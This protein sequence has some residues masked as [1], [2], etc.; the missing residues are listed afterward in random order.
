MREGER[1]TLE[2]RGLGSL[3]G[4]HREGVGWKLRGFAEREES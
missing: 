1:K 2:A 3:D 4:W